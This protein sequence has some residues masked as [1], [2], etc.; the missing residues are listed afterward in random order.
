MSSAHVAVSGLVAA[1]E[2]TCA[3]VHRIESAEFTS[4]CAHGHEVHS[5]L[6]STRRL[7]A[8]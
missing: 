1:S 6:G 5:D 7:A 4:S 8:V 3:F 2:A